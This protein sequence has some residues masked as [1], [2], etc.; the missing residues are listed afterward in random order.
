MK[1]LCETIALFIL[2]LPLVLTGCDQ[3][4]KAVFK[5][6]QGQTVDFAQFRGKWVILNYWA[7]WCKPCYKEIPALNSFYQRHK[8]NVVVLGVS[9]DQVSGKKL[10]QV[11]DKMKIQFPTLSS[12][13]AT[14]LGLGNVPG[15]P[16]T[17]IFNPQGKLSQRLLGIQDYASLASAI[18]K[19]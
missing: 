4:T 7:S 8:N 13:P 6:S 12:D 9:Y 18:S 14:A 15:L 1:R 5:D 3:P 11:I 17:Y 16:A 19:Q 2:L 10:Q